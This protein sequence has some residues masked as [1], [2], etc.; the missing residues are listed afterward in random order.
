MAARPVLV[1]L[2][3][4][5]AGCRSALAARLSERFDLV[6]VDSWS[7]ALVERR[8]VR[9]PAVLVIDEASAAGEQGGWI[10]TKAREG[11]FERVVVLTVDATEQSVDD[12]MIEINPATEIEKLAETISG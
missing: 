7:E 2:I 6:T 12:W 10:R 5:D 8:I 9:P 4:R 11:L 3:V 1:V